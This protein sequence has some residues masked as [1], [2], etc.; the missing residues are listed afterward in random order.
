MASYSIADYYRAAGLN[1]APE[2]LRLRQVPFEK[3]LK[4]L[5]EKTC[6]DLVRLYFG[7]SIPQGTKWFHSA[8]SEA[9]PSFSMY[10]NAREAAVL[11]AALLD[12]AVAAGEMRAGLAILTAF[13]S[14]LRTPLVR[15]ELVAEVEQCIRKKAVDD[16][17]KPAANPKIIKLPANSKHLKDA[18]ALAAA[19]DWQ[20][21]SNLF[22]NFSAESNEMT[23]TLTNQVY[24]VIVSLAG[25][26]E[27]LREEVEM[28][29]WH[30]GGWSRLL[31]RPFASMEVAQAAVLIGI[32][33]ADMSRNHAGPAAAPA[34]LQRTLSNGRKSLPSKVTI[35]DAV[36]TFP[37]DDLKTLQIEESLKNA[38]EI[39]P[40]LTAL[41]KAKEI[42]SGN[43]WHGPYSKATGLD[44]GAQLKPFA[45]AMQVYR[46]RLLL[47]ALS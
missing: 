1:S 21:A 43:V 40:I 13:A 31:E 6:L 27:D 4:E 45:L 5:D 36:D 2:T 47:S 32:D 19:G 8:F 38:A 26:V 12:A 22:K 10:D 39:C 34:I 42:G 41:S 24:S 35:R 33:L 14:G 20:A 30:I 18:D 15:P 44:V 28:L 46:E 3:M 23:K 37:E 7:L 9:D 17:D 11:S 16:R 25:H 29:W